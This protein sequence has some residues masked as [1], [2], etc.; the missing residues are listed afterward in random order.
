MA[1]TARINSGRTVE[2]SLAFIAFV[3]QFAPKAA[4]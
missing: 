4:W 2:K 1:N 3:L